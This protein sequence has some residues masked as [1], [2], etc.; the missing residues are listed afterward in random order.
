MDYNQIVNDYFR[1]NSDESKI[2]KVL[3]EE[4]YYSI[5][6][7]GDSICFIIK[8]DGGQNKRFKNG[9]MS[10]SLNSNYI[11]SGVEG[12]YSIIFYNCLEEKKVRIFVETLVSYASNNPIKSENLYELYNDISDVFKS[13]TFSYSYFIGV[14]GELIFI[15]K[16]YKIKGINMVK[17]YQSTNDHLVDFQYNNT[18]FEVKTS[19]TNERS[20]HINNDQLRG[21]G[22]LCSILIKEQNDGL[23]IND[24]YSRVMELFDGYYKKKAFFEN[25]LLGIPPRFVEM[26]FSIE[27]E[28]LKFYSFETIPKFTDYDESISQIKFICNLGGKTSLQLEELKL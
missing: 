6:K 26:K 11:V 20:H 19:V 7:Q 25:Y 23:T 24:I 14:V 21:H 12:V 10:I 28:N 3:F 18:N 9:N 17:Y 27:E 1:T 22:Y 16:M 5:G 4:K 8:S 13:I 15:S 2:I